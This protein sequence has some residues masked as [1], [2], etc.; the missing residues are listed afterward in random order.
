MPIY[1]FCSIL[2]NSCSRRRIAAEKKTQT[3][4]FTNYFSLKKIAIFSLEISWHFSFD[5]C[6]INIRIISNKY[7]QIFEHNQSIDISNSIHLPL[8]IIK[9][10][11]SKTFQIIEPIFLFVFFHWLPFFSTF[12]FSLCF[13]N[14]FS[15][16]L[17]LSNQLNVYWPKLFTELVN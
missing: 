1:F 2:L 14:C 15:L 10:I 8:I 5:L 3:F 9:S 13:S 16:S 7:E 11:E 12:K 17:S 4:F 6:C